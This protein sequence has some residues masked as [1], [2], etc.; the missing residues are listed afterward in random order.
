MSRRC[1]AQRAVGLILADGEAG[2]EQEEEEDVSEHEDN[3]ETNSHYN[4]VNE[5]DSEHPPEGK[6]Q[7]T[8]AGH[9]QYAAHKCVQE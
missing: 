8:A 4:N 6:A 1:T 7:P 2:C 5:L 9:P 3:V